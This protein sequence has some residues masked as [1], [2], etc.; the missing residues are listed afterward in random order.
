LTGGDQSSPKLEAKPGEIPII[1]AERSGLSDILA[2]VRDIGG[3]A[4]EVLVKV[5]KLIDDNQGSIN[6]T[7][8]NLNKFSKALGDNADKV[9]RFLASV[10]GAAEKIDRLASDLDEIVRSVDQKRVAH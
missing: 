7:V 4:D 2:T 1:V 3:R 8:Q 5:G 9:D 10:G 6:D